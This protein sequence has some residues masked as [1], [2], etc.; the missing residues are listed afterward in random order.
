MSRETKDPKSNLA[1][2]VSAVLFCCILVVIAVASI[3]HLRWVS[4]SVHMD[5]SFGASFDL[6][7]GSIV[8]TA[9]LVIACL[10]CFVSRQ[11]FG[12]RFMLVAEGLLALGLVISTVFA[13]DKRVA[14]NCASGLAVAVV[15]MHATYLLADRPWKIRLALIVLAALGAVFAEKTWMREMVEIDQTWEQYVETRGELWA[16]QGKELDDSA[17]KLF[18]ARMLS[19]DNGGFFFHGNLGASYLATLFMVGLAG[20]VVRLSEPKSI[21]RTVWIVVQIAVCLFIASALV[22]TYSKGAMLAWG[23]G[24]FCAAVLFAF[25]KRLA[26]NFRVSA[27]VIGL[28]IAAVLAGVVGYGLVNDTL[29]TLSMAYR[30][31]YWTASFDMFTDHAFTGVG[32]GNYG[33]YYLKYKLPEAVEEI[34]SPHNFIVQGFCEYGLI[35]GLGFL[36]LPLAVFYH[37]GRY[38]CVKRDDVELRERNGPSAGATLMLI[39]AGLA[40]VVLVFNQTNMPNFAAQMA[41]HLPYLLVFGFVAIIL[42]FRGNELGPIDN[43]YV[44][45]SVTI[46]LTAAL[47]VFAAG[48]LVNFTLFE[49]SMQFLFFFLAGLTLAAAKPAGGG[50]SRC[51]NKHGIALG[52]C[53]ALYIVYVA[54]P[55]C[56]AEKAAAKS[57]QPPGQSDPSVDM[58]YLKLSELTDRYSFDAHLPA[59]AAGR[60][61]EL[62]QISKTNRNKTI[63]M[64]AEHLSKASSRAPDFYRF[65]RSQAQCYQILSLLEPEKADSHFTKAEELYERAVALAPRSKML[66]LSTALTYLQH[67]DTVSALT[68]ERKL[69]LVRKAEEHLDIAVRLNNA[70]PEDAIRRFNERESS[71]ITHAR[72]RID[73]LLSQTSKPSSL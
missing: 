8:G 53:A 36:L 51:Y 47:V 35:G 52:I 45:G 55:A 42:A 38:S 20:A 54:A 61:L 19:R 14:I 32:A 7:Y 21:Y 3:S 9:I 67:A 50:A 23:V 70:L 69:A 24:A 43:G 5:G 71:H 17:V 44:G 41:E 62:S 49:P 28:L 57:D 66:Q 34:S 64:A 1:E 29:P 22:L 63:G 40:A 31:Q 18:E 4:P 12:M 30:W 46:F 26:R 65:Y 11:S 15:L 58:A 56:I 68:H 16:K 10:A 73:D 60:L 27:V 48:N 25:R 6:T 37:V 13:T 39:L 33:I 2:T 72:K 59:K